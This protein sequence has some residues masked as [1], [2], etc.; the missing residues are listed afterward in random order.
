MRP[1]PEVT[2]IAVVL[3]CL[4]SGVASFATPSPCRQRQSCQQHHHH[5]HDPLQ[6]RQPRGATTTPCTTRCRGGGSSS[7]MA[8]TG[9]SSQEPAADRIDIEGIEAKGGKDAAGIYGFAREIVE[10]EEASAPFRRLRLIG[11]A[12]PAFIA[13]FLAG[14]SLGGMAGIDEFKEV[15]ENLPNPLIDAGVV[16][17]AFYLWVE[18]VKTKRSSLALLK[19]EYEEQSKVPNRSSRRKKKAFGKKASGKKPAAAMK[20]PPSSPSTAVETTAAGATEQ[21]VGPASGK[22][23]FAGVKETLEAVNKQSYYQALALNKELEDKGVLPPLERAPGPPGGAEEVA[24]AED[25]SEASESAA[26]VPAE[27]GEAET[28][29]SPAGV[30]SQGGATKRRKKGKKAGKKAGRRNK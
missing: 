29:A 13:I 11:Y 21:E 16:G 26:G 15:S 6:Q 20:E 25:P 22:G 5:H 17:S 1:R 3:F 19:K 24:I 12:V 28:A 8:G 4:A 2:G 9:D 14:I 23:M 10:K 30:A 7:R 18:E 27:Q